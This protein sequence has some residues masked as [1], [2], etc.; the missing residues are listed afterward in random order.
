MGKRTIKLDDTLHQYLR[1][2][3]LRESDV[4]R[5]LREITAREE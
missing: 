3:S 2:H 1:E 5:K 4:L